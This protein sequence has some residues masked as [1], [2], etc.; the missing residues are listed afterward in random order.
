MEDP[1]TTQVPEEFCKTKN[2]NEPHFNSS[3]T[4]LLI[5]YSKNKMSQ[6]LFLNFSVC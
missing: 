1:K 4:E 2:G 5:T 6:S 3:E